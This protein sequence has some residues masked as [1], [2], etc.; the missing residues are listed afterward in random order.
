MVI[1]GFIN[2][3]EK[4]KLSQQESGLQRVQ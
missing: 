3:R 4:E 2:E 1:L